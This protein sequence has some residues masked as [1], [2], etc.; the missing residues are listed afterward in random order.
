M[1][2]L[3]V[4]LAAGETNLL[5]VAEWEALKE[6]RRVVFERHDHP[7]IARLGAAGVDAAPFDDEPDARSDDLALVAEPS[8]PR[9]VELA[10]AGARVTAGPA[11]APDDLTAA[12]AAPVA[13]RAAT[14]LGTL[15]ALMARLR[16][17]DGCPWDRQQTHESLV[18]HLVEEAYEVIDAIERGAVGADLAEELGDLLLQVAF[19]ARLAAQDARFDLADVADAISAKLVRRHPHVFGDVEV[20]GASEVLANWETIK[21][22]EKNRTDPFADIPRGLPALLDALKS[23]KRAAGLG[24]TADEDVARDAVL[25]ALAS[26]ASGAAEEGAGDALGDALFWLVALA[27]ARGIDPEMALRRTTA[28]FKEARASASERR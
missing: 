7:L 16:S 11:S 26:A 22:D 4:P 5:T 25:R 17:D 6:R 13:R 19:H 10:R 28:H 20:A 3:V 21:A 24:F 23:Q 1:P 18:V 9:V 15:T 12:H 14:S 27:R 2:L 8:S